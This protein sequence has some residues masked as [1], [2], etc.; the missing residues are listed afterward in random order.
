MSTEVTSLNHQSHEMTGT[1]A[2]TEGT[3]E[4]QKFNAIKGLE[5]IEIKELCFRGYYTI[6]NGGLTNDK[7]NICR[8]FLTAP[9]LEDMQKGL[10]NVQIVIG[11]CEHCF[12]KSCFEAYQR[13]GNSSC[14]IDTTPWN[15]EKE[16]TIRNSLVMDADESKVNMSTTSQKMNRD[17]DK[18][19]MIKKISILSS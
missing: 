16:Y 10:L 13:K 9:S 7:C 14:P 2:E 4:L 15:I 8:Q 18:P 6:K 12:H 11:K 1:T 19:T 3:E 17:T 5:R